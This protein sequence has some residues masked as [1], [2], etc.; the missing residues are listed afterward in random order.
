L[1]AVFFFFVIS[2]DSKLGEAGDRFQ[3]SQSKIMSGTASPVHER[4]K[5]DQFVTLIP[6][7]TVFAFGFL[8][9]I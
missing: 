8:I 6:Q 3:F 7:G 1:L 9:R 4:L 2:Y 5:R